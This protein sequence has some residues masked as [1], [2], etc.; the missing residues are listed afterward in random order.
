MAARAFVQQLLIDYS[1]SSCRA[2]KCILTAILYD[3]SGNL[4]RPAARNNLPFR[5]INTGISEMC[6]MLT[7][8]ISILGSMVNA[9]IDPKFR[10]RFGKSVKSPVKCHETQQTIF[11]SVGHVLKLVDFD[12]YFV[13]YGLPCEQ[14]YV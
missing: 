1:G 4:K 6:S 14:V 12:R 2:H 11:S 3:A 5:D 13:C 8:S 7:N 10:G 9:Y